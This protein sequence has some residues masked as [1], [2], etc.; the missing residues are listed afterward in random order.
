MKVLIVNTSQQTGGAAIA[1]SRLNKALGS[2]VESRMLVRDALPG[3]DDAVSLR[4][5]WRHKAR[6]VYERGVV[7]LNNGMRR[8]NLFSIDIANVGEDITRLP[9]FVEA[10]IIHLHW[11]NQ[12]MLSLDGIAKILKSGKPVVWTMHDMWPFTGICHY[13]EECKRYMSQCCHCPQL[14]GYGRRADLSWRT[15]CKKKQVYSQAPIV[16]VG[17][18]GWIASQSRKSALLTGHKVTNI[19]NPIDT[20]VF[21]PDDKVKSRS[22][23]GL[24]PDKNYILFM[25]MKVTDPRKGFSLLCNSLK[26]WG[27]K[28]PSTAAKTELLVVGRNARTLYSGLGMPVRAFDYISD[29][30][31][32]VN[33]YNAASV[34]VTPSLQDNLPNTI[35]EAMACGVPCIGCSIGGI[36]EMIDNGENGITVEP[37]QNAPANFAE[38]IE[39]VLNRNEN[40]RMSA[41]ARQKVIECYSENVVAGKYIELYNMLLNGNNSFS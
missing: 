19:P 38:A 18:S 15:F 40:I 36:P 31:T 41:N 8:D 34:Y 33:M 22:A 12:G 13:A 11:I 5:S 14:N 26:L 23:L 39:H 17:C 28:Y 30:R 27:L 10:D 35:M 1:A 6:F 24:D 32:M 37:G 7:W 9:E 2:E 3:T 29:T 4:G 25:A 20:G 21:A 16:F